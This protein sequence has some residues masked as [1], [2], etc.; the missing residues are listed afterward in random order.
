M[1]G[2]RVAVAASGGCDSTAL[3]HCTARQSR[4]LG[5]EVLALHVNHGLMP[6]ADAWLAQVRAQCRRWGVGFECQRLQ[7]S[8]GSGQSVEAW[9]RRER[10]RALAQMAAA[11]RPQARPAARVEPAATTPSQFATFVASELKKYEAVV[12]ASGASV[13]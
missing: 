9:A 11:S 3:L 12:K 8:P 1:P 7:G 13:D 5:V 2:P 10:Y 4:G 6:Q